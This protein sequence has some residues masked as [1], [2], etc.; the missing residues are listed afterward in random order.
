MAGNHNDLFEII[1]QFQRLVTWC[2][3]A[4]IKLK[5]I[6]INMDK[7][8]YCNKLRR[9]CFRHGFVPNVKEN[10]RNRKKS[11]PGPKRLFDEEAY[12]NC[13]VCERTWA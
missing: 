10:P 6:G 12:K 11:K 3:A 2:K 4:G 1:P 7:E 9:F 5:G 8:F 13:F